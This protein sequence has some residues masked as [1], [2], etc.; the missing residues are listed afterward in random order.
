MNVYLV[1]VDY[2]T[3]SDPYKIRVMAKSEEDALF[4]ARKKFDEK[5]TENCVFEQAKIE[6]TEKVQP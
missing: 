3:S 5:F 6:K 1:S 4:I 2:H